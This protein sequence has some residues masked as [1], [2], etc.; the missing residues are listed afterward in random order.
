MDLKGKVFYFETSAVNYLAER[1]T[2]KE[3]SSL[4][5]AYCEDGNVFYLSPVTLWEI[6]LTNNEE[7][8]E[9]I[10][11][12]CQHLFHEKL[13]NSPA[14]FIVNYINAECP[15][16]ETKYDFHTKLNIG[17]TWKDLCDDPRKTFVYDFDRLK[18]RTKHLQKLSKQLDKITNRIVLDSNIKDEEYLIQQGIN[19]LYELIKD[20]IVLPDIPSQKTIKLSILFIMYILCVEF[21]MDQS[22]YTEFW[23]GV[24]TDAVLDRILYIVRSKKSLIFRGP[25]Y[26]M[27]LMAFHQISLKEKSNRGLILDC[28]H[29]IYITYVDVFMTNDKHFKTLKQKELHPNFKRINYIE[30]IFPN[31]GAS[32]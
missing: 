9:R 7:Q 4:K 16:E 27:A 14:E 30:D 31:A 25:F 17:H 26:N 2:C 5:E 18:E 24:G 32:F 23:E 6:L 22:P 11:S 8:K 1:F 29:N 28:M 12:F 15:L 3:A 10:I 21:D 13:L 20:D 19:E